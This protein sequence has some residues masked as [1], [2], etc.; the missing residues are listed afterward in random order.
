MLLKRYFNYVRSTEDEYQNLPEKKG[1]K[2]IRRSAVADVVASE[3][4]ERAI[5][6]GQ[7]SKDAAAKERR[8]YLKR[9]AVLG[10]R[11]DL[12]SILERSE[13]KG[14]GNVP[15]PYRG[16]SGRYASRVLKGERVIV[17]L[18]ND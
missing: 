8:A 16:R 17:A 18:L 2:R 14:D 7:Q 1:Q 9:Y 11:K 12:R 4:A 13:G 15:G 5:A 10:A 3:R 6:S